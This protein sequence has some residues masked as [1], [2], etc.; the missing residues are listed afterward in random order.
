MTFE[1]MISF[2]IF[3]MLTPI[4]MDSIQPA[5]YITFADLSTF[6][7]WAYLWGK[8]YLTIAHVIAIPIRDDAL[9]AKTEGENPR[10][11]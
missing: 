1:K 11:D 9:A 3:P 7:L 4:A 10:K 8:T 5:M 6:L 2:A